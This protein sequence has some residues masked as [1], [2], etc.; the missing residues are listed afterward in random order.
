MSIVLAIG[1]VPDGGATWHLVHTLGR[2]RA[3]E[4]IAT[5]EKL[6]AQKCLD[7]GLCNRVVPADKLLELTQEWARELAVW[8]RYH[9][10]LQLQHTVL[11]TS[12]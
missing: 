10:R 3:Y 5:G 11:T 6:K 7:W 12:L 2:K 8:Y 4:I 1:L 9:M